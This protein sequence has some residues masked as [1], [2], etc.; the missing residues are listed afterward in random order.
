MLFDEP[1]SLYTADQSYTDI[2][3]DRGENDHSVKDIHSF[4]DDHLTFAQLLD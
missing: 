1:S 2:L 3:L 4:R